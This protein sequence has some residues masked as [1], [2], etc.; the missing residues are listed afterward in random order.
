VCSVWVDGGLWTRGRA[1]PL[2][3]SG[4]QQQSV[5]VSHSTLCNLHRVR[6]LGLEDLLEK[7][8]ATYSSILA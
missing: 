5:R 3:P 6:S 7:G 1:L 8:S 2:G 4:L